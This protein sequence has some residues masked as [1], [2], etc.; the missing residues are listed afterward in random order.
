MAYRVRQA[1]LDD[2]DTLVHHRVAMFVD[3]GV[4]VDEATLAPAF[5]EWLRREM[6]AG[7]YRAWLVEWTGEDTAGSTRATPV[8]GAGATIIPWP[9]GPKYP[10]DRLAF[11]YNVYTEPEHRRRGLARV[12]MDA[13]HA[14]CRETGVTSVALNA[15]ADG[16]PLYTALGYSVTPNPMMFYSLAWER[17]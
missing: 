9:P 10:G 8:A 1:T 5:A 4:E 15:S 6:P 16:Q 7:S 13:L 3:M 11:V 17:H 2:M 14:W 12:A